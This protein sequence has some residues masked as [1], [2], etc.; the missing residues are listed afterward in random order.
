MTDDSVTKVQLDTLRRERE[1]LIAKIRES[2]ETIARSQDLLR[3]IDAFIAR[4]EEKS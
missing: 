2:E 1:L 3:R 4:A